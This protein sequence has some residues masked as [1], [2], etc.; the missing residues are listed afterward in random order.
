MTARA[1]CR[2]W[3]IE[4]DGTQWVFGDTRRPVDPSRPCRRCGRKPTAEGYDHCLGHVAGASSAC[5]GH[6]VE[7]GFVNFGGYQPNAEQIDWSKIEYP[8]TAGLL[9]ADRY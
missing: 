1:H 9:D 5:C 3:P 4:H 2:G 6:G 7:T 8:T